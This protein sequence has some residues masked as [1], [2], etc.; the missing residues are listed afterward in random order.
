VNSEERL[1]APLVQ[2]REVTAEE[3]TA[4]A[5]EMLGGGP[6]LGIG[7]PRASLESNYALRALV[8]PENFY[9][10]MCDAEGRLVATMLR[11]L[12][13]GPARTPSL[14]EVER[15]DA[16]LVL[17]EDL[18]HTAPLLALAVRQATLNAAYPR[19]AALRIPRWD[20]SA[21]RNALQAQRGPLFVA[22]PDETKLDAEA[23]AVYRAAPEALARLAEEI[24]G[25]GHG[26][27]GKWGG[28]AE[29][30]LAAQIAQAL[31]AAE[32][33]LIIAG[34]G[35]GSEALV[36]AAA[37]VAGALC[38]AGKAAGLCFTVPE[39][40]SAGLA[41]LEPRPLSEAVAR[42][43]AGEAAAV[44]VL[45]N[46]LFRRTDPRSAETL[47]AAEKTIVVDHL[48]NATTER[49]E[50]VLPAATWAESTGTL[51]NNEG[52]A[53]RFFSVF[54]PE[55]DTVRASWR[56]LTE[57]KGEAGADEDALREEMA[58]DVS[59]LA[60]TVEAAPGAAFRVRGQRIPRQPHRY[61]GRTAMT[62]NLSVHEPQAEQD[63]DGPLNYS[64]EGYPGEPPGALLS[65]VWAPGWN[66]AQAV[67]KFQIEVGGALR[68]GDP[69]RRLIEP[70][71]G[72]S[73]VGSR[74]SEVPRGESEVREG[75]WLL[76]P[77]WHIFGSEELSACAPGIAELAP[78]A[79]VALGSADA[80]RLRVTEGQAVSVEV[81]G[82]KYELRL[83]VR[84]A[85]AEG[86]ALV[87]VGLRDGPRMG[88][89]AR[90]RI[91]AR[92]GGA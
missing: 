54:S 80:A 71:E 39:C 32:R 26:E 31:S 27:R 88:L 57:L 62:A 67:N 76:L 5:R 33:P 30:R 38:A 92:E 28:E 14:R 48:R 73:A 85:L 17:G 42:V 58:R 34:Y 36:R 47:L 8:G 77:A 83:R 90:G 18:H 25:M 12:R 56:W 53:Q 43:A 49:A 72:E 2:G 59:A 23:T 21:V 74:K 50:V 79:Y 29:G 51:V 9:S 86:V 75:E 91:V 84:P 46:D 78:E 40:N 10:G 1:R 7:S 63:P 89:P 64:M 6:A 52:R 3:A 22:T 37:E 82:V 70:G 41:L 4:R 45:E 44:V 69:G 13:E 11:L 60:G 81:D 20:D 68:G 24:A 19:A 65:R 66:S 87:P 55:E 15:A 35:C 61:S 16:V